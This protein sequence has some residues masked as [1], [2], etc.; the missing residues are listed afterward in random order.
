M[1]S[2]QLQREE[3]TKGTIGSRRKP[4]FAEVYLSREG[5]INVFDRKVKNILGQVSLSRRPH[6]IKFRECL[7]KTV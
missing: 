1:W 2:I 4:P 7:R 6:G 3:E 5:I